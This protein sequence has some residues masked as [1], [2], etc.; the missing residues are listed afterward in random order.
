MEAALE[1][2]YLPE[3]RARAALRLAADLY[4]RALAGPREDASEDQESR[5]QAFLR[6]HPAVVAIADRRVGRRL[7]AIEALLRIAC[8]RPEVFEQECEVVDASEREALALGEAFMAGLRSRGTRKP[9]L[10][11]VV[12]ACESEPVMCSGL[13][14]ENVCEDLS[15]VLREVCAPTGWVAPDWHGLVPPDWDKFVP[16]DEPAEDED[17]Q[18]NSQEKEQRREVAVA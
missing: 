17:E 13:G 9:V 16:D 6:V 18:S 5:R 1:T 15:A 8:V 3:T 10:S 4:E 12:L 14:E 11:P 7:D 2:T